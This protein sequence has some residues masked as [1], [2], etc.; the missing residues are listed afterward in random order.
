MLQRNGEW[1]LTPTCIEGEG[2]NASTWRQEK[3]EALESVARLAGADERVEMA[4]LRKLHP[5]P[6]H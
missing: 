3:K 6:M 5:E 1:L 4:L 2:T